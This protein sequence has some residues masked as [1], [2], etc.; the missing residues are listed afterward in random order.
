MDGR[1]RLRRINEVRLAESISITSN[2]RI[3]FRFEA[4]DVFDV[5]NVDLVDYH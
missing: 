2:W 3:T 5:F 1:V 4:G